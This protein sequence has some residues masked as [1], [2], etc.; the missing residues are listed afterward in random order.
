MKHLKYILWVVVTL[1]VVVL[2]VQNHETMSTAV[3]FKIKIFSSIYQSPLMQLYY[4]VIVVFLFG[5]IVGSI[6]GMRQ[7]FQLTRE[8][9]ALRSTSQDMDKE[10]NSLRNLPITNDVSGGQ[11][12]N[13]P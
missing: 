13:N 1:I 6:F 3:G 10:L 11:P 12:E 5:F 4:V 7:R 9:K 8:L 2:M